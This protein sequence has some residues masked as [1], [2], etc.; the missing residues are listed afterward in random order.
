M[1]YS[2]CKFAFDTV[3]DFFTY[4]KAVPFIVE[5]FKNMSEEEYAK[6]DKELRDMY[7]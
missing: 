6:V 5:V 4:I 3:E 7:D 1:F 2:P